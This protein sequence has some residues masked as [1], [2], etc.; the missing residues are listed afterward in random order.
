MLWGLQESDLRNGD[1]FTI[2]MHMF[3]YHTACPMVH[4]QEE[5]GHSPTSLIPCD[6]FLFPRK[7]EN[8]VERR[9]ID[10]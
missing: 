5:Y 3:T 2:M 4:G 1:W 7:N 10:N 8:E 6:C 9:D